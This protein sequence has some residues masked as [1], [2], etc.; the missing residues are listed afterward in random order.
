MASP[1]C[2]EQVMRAPESLVKEVLLALCEDKDVEK[3][4]LERL[5][6]LTKSSGASRGLGRKRKATDDLAICAHLRLLS[7]LNP[8]KV[9][10]LSDAGRRI[11]SG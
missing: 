1:A 4:A 6:A 8:R 5:D 2:R 10:R 7:C 3:T 9:C 11:R